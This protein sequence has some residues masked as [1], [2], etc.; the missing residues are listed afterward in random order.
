MAGRKIPELNRGFQFGKSL[1][2]MVHFPAISMFDDIGWSIMLYPI[3]PT[4]N[5]ISWY[6]IKFHEI[7]EFWDFWG[8][9]NYFNIVI[10]YDISKTMGMS[11]KTPWLLYTPCPVASHLRPCWVQRPPLQNL[12]CPGT[13]PQALRDFGDFGDFKVGENGVPS[14]HCSWWLLVMTTTPGELEG[15]TMLLINGYIATISML[16]FQFSMLN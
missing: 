8:N 9:K 11:H 16:I 14:K 4:P 3:I 7:L 1:I 10:W 13:V 2:S 12:Q 15:S 6:M 5:D